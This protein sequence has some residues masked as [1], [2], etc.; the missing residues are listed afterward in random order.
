MNRLMADLGRLSFGP[1]ESERGSG[2]TRKRSRTIRTPQ[3]GEWASRVSR[4]PAVREGLKGF[5]RR[6]GEA[7]GVVMEGRDIGTVIFPD[8]EFKFFLTASLEVRGRRRHAEWAEKG[9]ESALEKTIEQIEK[10][11]YNDRSRCLAP[12]SVPPGAVTVD[13]SGLTVDEVVDL[14]FRRVKAEP[15]AAA[16]GDASG[17]EGRRPR[18]PLVPLGSTVIRLAAAVLFRLR[19]RGQEN[20]PDSGG[21]IIAANHASYLD[22][23]IVGGSIRRQ[24]RYMAAEELFRIPVFGPLIRSVGSFPVK[25]G[26]DDRSALREAVR[27]LKRGHLLL[28]FPEGTRSFNGELGE[29]KA[30]IGFI[31]LH[32]GVPVIPAFVEGRTRRSSRTVV[33]EAGA[34]DRPVWSSHRPPE[35]PVPRG[36]PPAR[37]YQAV[38]D[39]VMREI[40]KLRP[41]RRRSIVNGQWSI[42]VMRESLSAA[43]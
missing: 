42:A 31:A 20:I 25:R 16:R 34:C 28:V 27:Q 32:A 26:E 6:M 1:R 5:Q 40:A 9:G 3:A 13:T 14:L 33:G 30:G 41:G 23:P 36:R 11:D 8:A 29:G 17:R 4:S 39:R 15:P 37:A 2:S 18:F 38:A 10:R 12:L 24:V 21:A 19:V 43:G 22:P 7:G 35:G